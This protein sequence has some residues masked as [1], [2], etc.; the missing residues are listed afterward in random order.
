MQVPVLALKPSRWLLGWLAVIH[1]LAAVAIWLAVLPTGWQLS[2]LALIGVSLVVSMLRELRRGGEMLI[3]QTLTQWRLRAISKG[4]VE[5]ELLDAQV[6][7]HV[8]ILRFSVAGRWWPRPVVVVSDAVDADSHRRL[9]AALTAG[10]MQ[11]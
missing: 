2:L 10:G 1:G 4:E 11:R 5:A 8:V 3:P 9:R 6:F 7:R